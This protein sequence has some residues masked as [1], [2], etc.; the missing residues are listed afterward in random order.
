MMLKKVLLSEEDQIDVEKQEKSYGEQ[1]ITLDLNVPIG[2]IEMEKIFSVKGDS[3]VY[4]VI[5]FFKEQSINA[6]LVSDEIEKKLGIFTEYDFLHKIAM[7]SLNIKKAKVSEFMTV[8]FK[9]LDVSSPIKVAL[10]IFAH[11]R[12]KHIPVKDRLEFKYMLTPNDVL[13]FFSCN[14]SK[15]VLNLPP[16]PFKETREINGG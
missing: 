12:F 4:D 6:V 16:A 8:N 13:N 5:E 9:F 11:E 2:K 10:N 15:S 7:R 14:S 3:T 1:I